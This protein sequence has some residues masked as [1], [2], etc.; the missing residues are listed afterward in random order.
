MSIYQNESVVVVSPYIYKD[1]LTV[2]N[3]LFSPNTVLDISAGQCRD[4]NNVMDMGVGA[5]YPPVSQFNAVSAPLLLNAAVNGVNGL[6]AGSLGASL[7]YS[8]Y[9]IADSRYKNPVACLASLSSNAAPIMPFGYDSYR[10]ISY[11]AT[12]SSSHWYS[13]Y[14]SGNGS[15]LTF[16]YASPVQLITSGNA[17]TYAGGIIDLVSVVPPVQNVI[18]CTYSSLVANAV[19]DQLFMQA[20]GQTGDAVNIISPI[21]GTGVDSAHY[22]SY[23]FF[24]ARLDGTDPTISYKVSTNLATADISIKSFQVSV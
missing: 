1:G 16:Q 18:I 23:D 17:V 22:H 9:I 15:D 3:D 20:F 8:I 11:W 13:G 19:G 2:S 12:D 5:L 7:M 24:V 14:Y 10:I 4:S 6:D 21:I